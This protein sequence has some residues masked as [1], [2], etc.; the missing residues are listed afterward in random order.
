MNFDE[1]R[2]FFELSEFFSYIDLE[3]QFKKKFDKIDFFKDKDQFI[4]ACNSFLYLLPRMIRTYNCRPSEFESRVELEKEIDEFV[5]KYNTHP[6]YQNLKED[7]KRVSTL[8]FEYYRNNKVEDSEL[9]NIFYG[10]MY[11]LF[12][13]EYKRYHLEH[14]LNEIVNTYKFGALDELIKLFIRSIFIDQMDIFKREIDF[15]TNYLKN[16]KISIVTQEKDAE[17]IYNS[18]DL[19]KIYINLKKKLLAM[20]FLEDN[21]IVLKNFNYNKTTFNESVDNLGDYISLDEF[22]EISEFIGTVDIDYHG[23]YVIIYKYNNICLCHEESKGFFIMNFYPSVL[24]D[25]L[26]E[27]RDSVK[28]KVCK[29]K[30]LCKNLITQ[31]LLNRLDIT[32]NDSQKR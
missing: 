19:Q 10:R 8:E 16:V 26:F 18:N 29:D 28:L 11:D 4:L 6:F 22:F 12:F 21:K 14:L 23:G 27:F 32:K 1:A 24:Y 3:N 2:K 7:I 5:N 31:D 20:T 13:G 25:E 9:F 30:E 15:F 17:E